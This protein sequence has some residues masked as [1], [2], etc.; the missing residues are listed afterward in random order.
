MAPSAPVLGRPAHHARRLEILIIPLAPLSVI[1]HQGIAGISSLLMGV[2]MILMGLVMWF[3]PQLR[4]IAGIAT[5]LFALTSFVTSN[6][7]GFLIGMLL[8][9]MGGALS[10]AWTPNESPAPEGSAGEDDLAGP[11][12]R[13]SGRYGPDDDDDSLDSLLG[14]R[15][16]PEAAHG[17]WPSNGDTAPGRRY[18]YDAPVDG[19]TSS[20]RQSGGQMLALAAL[21]LVVLASG[22]VAPKAVPQDASCPFFW[23]SCPWGQT[24]PSPTATP[25]PTGAPT[26]TQAPGAPGKP[27]QP[28]PTD[29]PTPCPSGAAEP[30]GAKAGT[31]L[32]ARANPGTQSDT[33]PTADPAG[34]EPGAGP[35]GADAARAEPGAGSAASETPTPGGTATATASPGATAP[36][37]PGASGAPS[38]PGAPAGAAECDDGTPVPTP[39]PTPT[40]P[41]ACEGKA[42]NLPATPPPLGSAAARRLAAELEPCFKS[43]VKAGAVGKADTPRA[44]NEP[45]VLTAESMTMTGLAYNGVVSVPTRNGSVRALDFTMDGLT[46]KDLAQKASFGTNTLTVRSTPGNSRMEGNISLQV[47]RMTAK[48]LGLIP[49]TFTPENPPPLTLPILYFTDVTSVNVFVRAD[50]LRLPKLNLTVG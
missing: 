48:L 47:T 27:G 31:D 37:G 36:A 5:V 23:P 44:A 8:G 45:S 21:P 17:G 9:I 34:A 33:K 35:A 43:E 15:P 12:E 6:F 11:G 3:Q 32:A 28:S 2:L 50:S 20:H 25:T 38:G 22:V 40:T 29:V 10:F 14:D 13:R 7:G 4:S 41:P 24:T 1:I 42:E 16:A 46:I 39:T 30:A 49:V 18:S 26:G 19:P